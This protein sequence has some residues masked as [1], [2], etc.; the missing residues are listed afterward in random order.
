MYL[1]HIRYIMKKITADSLWA[2]GSCFRYLQDQKKGGRLKGAGFVEDNLKRLI[3]FVETS[4][5]AVCLETNAF[6][7]LRNKL[8][9]FRDLDV[10]ARLDEAQAKAL[11]DELKELRS[12]L[13]AELRTVEAYTLTPK[14]H[15]V[16][17]LMGAVPGIFGQGV[18]EKLPEIAQFDLG[19]AGKCIALERPTAAAF[20]LMRAIEA[21]LRIFY[22]R[23]IRVKRANVTMW[24]PIIAELRKKPALVK[25][26]K[27]LL[28]HLDNI[29]ANFRNPTQHP[30]ATYT[31]AEAEN[32][33]GLSIDVLCRMEPVL[34]AK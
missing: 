29:R 28:D 19:E 14:R 5:L 16:D 8:E 24:G 32:L 27:V 17:N 34:K 26:H 1:D 15:G 9:E 33:L 22:V 25:K 21:T 4:E 10:D 31:T 11:V 18:F 12:T 6:G 2:F 20:H 13:I 3:K 23:A 30:E 7:N